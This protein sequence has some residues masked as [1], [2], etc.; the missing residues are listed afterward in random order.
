MA[1]SYL[2]NTDFQKI[3]TLQSINNNRISV[4][5]VNIIYV[6]VNAK[7]LVIFKILIKVK[8]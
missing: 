5:F 7:Q 3:K 1:C 8:V 2:Q 6:K 4:T